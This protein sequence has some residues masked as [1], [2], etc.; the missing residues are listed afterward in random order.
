MAYEEIIAK[1]VK[2]EYEAFKKDQS[3]G[4]VSKRVKKLNGYTFSEYDDAK[5]AFPHFRFAHISERIAVFLHN[6]GGVFNLLQ[7]VPKNTAAE[8]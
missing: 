2:S 7:I 5:G 1:S 6:I 3:S 8:A 4:T